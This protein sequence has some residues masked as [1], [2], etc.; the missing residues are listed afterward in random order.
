MILEQCLAHGRCSVC[1]IPSSLSPHDHPRSTQR[2][3]GMVVKKTDSRGRQPGL[4]HLLY[5]VLVVD[6][7]A[8]N[9]ASVCLSSFICTMEVISNSL[10]KEL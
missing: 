1:V 2:L 10:I 8:S 4:N 6:P 7:W 9:L 5:H 3:A